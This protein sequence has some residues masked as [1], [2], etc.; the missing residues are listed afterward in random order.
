ML[1]DG[2]DRK[3]ELRRRERSRSCDR[4]QRERVEAAQARLAA[5]GAPRSKWIVTPSDAEMAAAGGQIF[6]SNLYH[7]S[8]NFTY[9]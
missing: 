9:N 3:A 5:D 8:R 4:I 1:K 7:F 2:E 6:Y